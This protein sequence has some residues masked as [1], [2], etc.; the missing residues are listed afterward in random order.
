MRT[1]I[2]LIA[3]LAGLLQAD[4]HTIS[5][6]MPAEDGETCVVCYGRCTRDDVAY[7]VDGQR[8]AVMKPLEQ[9]FLKDPDQYIA[10]YRPNSMQFGGPAAV[11]QPMPPNYLWYGVFVVVALLGA[12][13]YSMRMRRVPATRAPLPC[14]ACG[15]TN[16]PSA[17]KCSHCGA[18]LTP[19]VQSEVQS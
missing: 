3:L 2:L 6:P 17:A 4:D 16:H 9:D 7:L 5:A 15:G 14:P 8:F 1:M 12:G 19:A 10:A 18:T 11:Q 13:V